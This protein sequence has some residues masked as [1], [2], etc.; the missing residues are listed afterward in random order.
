[1]AARCG[2]S[3]ETIRYYEAEGLIP[4]A[5]RLSGQR[6]YDGDDE[7]WIRFL[8][9]LRSSGL[10]VSDVRAFVDLFEAGPATLVHRRAMLEAHAVSIRNRIAELEAALSVVEI[11]AAHLKEAEAQ[12]NH[13]PEHAQVPPSALPVLNL[14]D[15]VRAR[16]RRQR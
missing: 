3:I 5:R 11:K 15:S 12:S 7:I 14:P 4:M 8:M 6:R 9:A 1:M 2:L 13:A 16:P 10:G